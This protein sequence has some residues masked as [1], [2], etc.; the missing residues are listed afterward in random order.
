MARNV[1]I[2]TRAF[3]LLP[4]TA[5]IKLYYA[6]V[7]PY[8]SYCN[9]VWASTYK[10]SLRKLIVIQKRAIR[11]I[12]GANYGSSTKQLFSDL[13]LLNIEQIRLY[14]VGEFMFRFH[15][16][17]LPPAFADF[18]TLVSKVHTYGTRQCALYHRPYAR[19]NVRRFSIRVVGISVWECIPL[20]VRNSSNVYTF[21]RSLRE[22]LL[23]DS[24]EWAQVIM[25]SSRP[26][27][28]FTLS[29]SFLC[30]FLTFRFFFHLL[31]SWL[32]AMDC[33]CSF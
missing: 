30:F 25:R 2:L 22:H 1:G 13:N 28:L 15:H 21:K 20:F 8:L 3:R 4:K 16:G 10:T 31:S 14:Q 33:F 24:I 32:V 27:S 11:V 5:R 29:E 18:Y 19:T 26:L 7:F 6:I 23:H 12:A 17:L 9:I